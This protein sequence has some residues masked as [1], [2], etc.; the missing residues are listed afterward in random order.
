MT[1]RVTVYMTREDWTDFLFLS[2]DP[3][4][5]IGPH[6]KATILKSELE[7]YERAIDLL[8][9]LSEEVESDAEYV[10]TEEEEEE[11]VA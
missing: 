6:Y 9:R 8:K 3:N 1:E 4:E 5:F 10:P 11:N 7:A 2:T